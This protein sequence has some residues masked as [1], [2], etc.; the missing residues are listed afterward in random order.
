MPAPTM[1]ILSG[2]LMFKFAM[3]RS[4]CGIWEQVSP[5]QASGW[6]LE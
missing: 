3:A 2:W 6:A 1:T 4:V 5:V